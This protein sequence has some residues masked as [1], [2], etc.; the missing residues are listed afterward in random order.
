MKYYRF[1]L[2]DNIWVFRDLAYGRYHS[3]FDHPY[4]SFLREIHEEFHT[5]IQLN[6]YYETD[7][8]CLAQM[9]DRYKEE[10]EENARWLRLSFHA[11]ANDPRGPMIPP[12]P[13]RVPAMMS[14]LLTAPLFKKKF[15]GLQVR[16]SYLLLRRYTTAR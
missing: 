5:K 9:P 14:C 8:F 10:W 15:A 4:L 2:D 16:Q 13:M 7:E 1:S 6:V 3:I 11:R 12:L